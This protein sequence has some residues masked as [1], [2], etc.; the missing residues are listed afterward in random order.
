MKSSTSSSQAADTGSAGESENQRYLGVVK[1]FAADKCYG[2][3]ERPPDA[4]GSKLADIFVH[5]RGVRGTGW[6]N[7][8]EAQVVD[9][10]IV[11]G[12]KGPQAQD[13]FV[14][15]EP[16]EDH[17]LRP[18]VAPIPDPEPSLIEAA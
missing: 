3:I 10:E 5:F 12:E 8:K 14:V 18:A 9:F 2:F 11:K 16:H 1:W 7:L 6:R 4:D 15:A 13:T 17:P